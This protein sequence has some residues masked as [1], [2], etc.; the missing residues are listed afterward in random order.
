MLTGLLLQKT[1][2]NLRRYSLTASGE[3][4]LG[5]E[6]FDAMLNPSQFKLV[7]GIE[8]DTD[9]ALGQIGTE[10]RFSAV[11]PETV[12]FELVLDGTGVVPGPGVL[13]TL[14]PRP[15][16]ALMDD[17]LQV[18]YDYVG[19]KHEPSPVRV[20]WGTFLF[21]GRLTAMNTQYTLFK[22]SG[23]PLRAKVSLD[24]V[25]QKSRTEEARQANR[26]SPDL[27]HSVEVLSGDTLPLL[28]QRIY[29]DTR[30]YL[31]VARFNRLRDFR[32]LTPGQRLHFPPLA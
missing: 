17:L 23:D 1:R 12:S 4:R 3:K 10:A 15:V 27:S 19:D 16:T 2:L 24:F 18:V 7:R 30:H 31:A 32:R 9:P 26:S 20:L 8:Y 29:G 13:P 5:S 22:P 25:G 14:L 21:Y 6:Q 28:C 11:K